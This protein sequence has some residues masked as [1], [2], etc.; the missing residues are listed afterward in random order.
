MEN[1]DFVKLE[2]T[3]RTRDNKAFDTTDAGIAKAE[4]IFD[5]KTRYAPML[6]VVGRGV[7]V[8]GLDEALLDA[9]VGEQKRITIPPERGFGLRDASLVRVVSAAE[10]RRQNVA[11]APGMIV[12][13]DGRNA[14]VKSV[15]SGRVV[16]DL[17][18][19]LASSELTYDFKVVEKITDAKQKLLAL[20]EANDLSVGD[21]GISNGSA[22][23]TFAAAVKK[24][25]GFLVRKAK[26]VGDALA[27]LPELTRIRI[28]EEYERQKE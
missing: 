16:V 13:I 4:G 20:A 26:F 23:V 6:V 8:K 25:A 14:V 28:V 7:V 2:Y 19:A 12:N 22:E 5:E 24:D 1:G 9:G 10:F 21:A 3:G 17:N 18:H 11:P 27:L 15:N